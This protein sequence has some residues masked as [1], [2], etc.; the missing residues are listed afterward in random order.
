MVNVSSLVTRYTLNGTQIKLKKFV[1]IL[2]VANNLEDIMNDITFGHVL[3]FLRNRKKITQVDISN[4]IHID[5]TVISHIE[6]DNYSLTKKLVKEIIEALKEL[7]G[8]ESC[9]EAIYLLDKSGHKTQSLRTGVLKLFDAQ[10]CEDISQSFI[11]SV[12]DYHFKNDYFVGRD[13]DIKKIVEVITKNK[14]V[15]IYG[16]PG[17]GKSTLVTYLKQDS[18]LN[19]LFPDGIITVRL[20]ELISEQDNQPEN[21][22]MVIKKL[23][24]ELGLPIDNPSTILS[25]I[26]QF[27]TNKDVLFLIDNAFE[28][29]QVSDILK[30]IIRDTKAK[31]IITTRE[32]KLAEILIQVSP[33]I[34]GG[35]GY[36]LDVLDKNSAKRIILNILEDYTLLSDEESQLLDDLVDK[37]QRLPLT[38]DI[39]GRYLHN[40][41]VTMQGKLD[42]VFKN[43]LDEASLIIKQPIST[44]SE[45][46]V[47]TSLMISF[48]RLTS[49][50]KEMF[51]M[52]GVNVPYPYELTK[53]ELALLWGVDG[54]TPLNNQETNKFIRELTER[55]MLQSKQDRYW[56]HALLVAFARSLWETELG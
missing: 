56:T 40:N 6:A 46:T 54:F 53:D 50:C 17:V 21:G 12:Y 52:L 39:V 4:E 11:Q 5:S 27:I 3:K 23:A 31:I 25:S 20:N 41:W 34:G 37:L 15:V 35:A 49:E 30:N 18:K 22:L 14:F 10:E 32:K 33:Q 8:F 47:E 2:I 43:F 51:K 29:G 48:N 7:S 44:I 9:S 55:G 24:F 28:L 36:N 26:R 42:K 38:M 1:G 19:K 13:K 16:F 45:I